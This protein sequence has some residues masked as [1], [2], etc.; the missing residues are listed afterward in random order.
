MLFRSQRGVAGVS[1]TVTCKLCIGRNDSGAQISLDELR[2]TV[3]THLDANELPDPP[4]PP[5][6]V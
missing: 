3:Y 1:E 5:G 2:F 6:G 4:D